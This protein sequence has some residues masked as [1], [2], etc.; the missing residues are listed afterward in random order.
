MIKSELK[1]KPRTHL[2]KPLIPSE[3]LLKMKNSRINSQKKKRKTLKPLLMIL[4]NGLN[5]IQMLK[6]KNTREN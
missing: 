4:K 5:Q 1:L 2:N 3:T 6:L